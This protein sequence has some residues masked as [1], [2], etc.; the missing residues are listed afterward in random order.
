MP[1]GRAL[2]AALT[3]DVEEWYHNCCIEE[4]VH[5]DKRPPLA[6][7]LDHLIPV[8]LDLIETLPARATLF[9][10]GEVV[11]R[12]P[13]RIREAVSRG[14]EIACHGDLHLRANTR[15]VSDFRADLSRAKAKLED[16]T[17]RRILGF[18]APEWSLRSAGN[19]RFRAVADCGFAYDSSLV[20]A[21]GSGSPDNPSEPTRFTWPDGSSLLEF[22]A[23][24]WA[25]PLRLPAGGWCGRLARPSWLRATLLRARD[26]NQAP[27]IVVHPWEVVDRPVPGVLT[28]LGRF[29]HEAGR[30]GFRQRFLSAFSGLRFEPIGALHQRCRSAGLDGEETAGGAEPTAALAPMAATP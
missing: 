18:R 20:R 15:S 4:Y 27:V 19:P 2:P 16:L 3:V 24:V 29:L 7:E 12:C 30:L 6:N 22:P 9:V 1:V 17:G 23:M 28:G 5:P 11:D 25:G 14:H 21:I 13:S 8:L 26:R 10:L